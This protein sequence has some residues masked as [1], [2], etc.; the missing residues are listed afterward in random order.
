MVFHLGYCII[1]HMSTLKYTSLTT[2]LL[3]TLVLFGAAC[4]TKVIPRNSNTA[5]QSTQ[6][7]TPSIKTSHYNLQPRDSRRRL[8]VYFRDDLNV[9]MAPYFVPLDPSS[10]VVW[11]SPDML[12]L[13]EEVS[14][15][16]GGW[17][18]FDHNHFWLNF[19]TP[20]KIEDWV[21]KLNALPEVKQAVPYA[22]PPK[23]A[24]YVLKANDSKA[25]INVKFL[26]NFQVIM[27]SNGYP[28]DSAG[29][30][31]MSPEVVSVF[32]M[33]SKAGGKWIYVGDNN[34]SLST[35]PDQIVDWVDKLNALP[36]VEQAAPSVTAGIVGGGPPMITRGI[37]FTVLYP[38]TPSSFGCT[39]YAGYETQPGKVARTYDEWSEL[40]NNLLSGCSTKTLAPHIIDFQKQ[41]I[42]AVF[43]GG[44]CAATH[45]DVQSVVPSNN[46]LVVH[47]TTTVAGCSLPVI[48]YPFTLVATNTS[49]LPIDFTSETLNQHS[50][51]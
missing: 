32:E 18:Y 16:G 45:V 13:S 24:H 20:V 11:Q 39:P 28:V 49:T 21:D 3:A 38:P 48:S 47:S 8:G 40:Y 33:I 41:M 29:K 14:K 51:P 15:S 9:T 4:T 17:E 34:F 36:E 5:P 50:F 6:G 23:P 30:G 42:I 27:R 35:S 31:L 44:S 10:A 12:A 37:Q 2:S 22:L 26:D 43:V 1:N 46:K 7:N 19:R 25:D